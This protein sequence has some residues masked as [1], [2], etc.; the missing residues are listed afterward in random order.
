[1]CVCY[2]VICVYGYMCVCMIY[3]RQ[4]M[5]IYTNYMCV[6]KKE[7]LTKTGEL[8]K[9]DDIFFLYHIRFSLTLNFD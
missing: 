8:E 4:C 2:M 6:S 5:D 3:V 9:I 1:M 7:F